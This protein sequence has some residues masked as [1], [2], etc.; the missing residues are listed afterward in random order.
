MDHCRIL[1]VDDQ[2]IVRKRICA[3]LASRTDFEVCAE[4][5]N[6]KEAVEKVLALNPDLIVLDITMPVM[7]GLEAARAIGKLC[8]QTPI[9]MLSVHDSRQL[10]E[11]AQKIGVRGYVLKTEAGKYLMPAVDAVLHQETFFPSE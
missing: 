1:V 9:L 2:D 3:T 7:N 8:P 6:G 4:A 10:I 11:E 5:V